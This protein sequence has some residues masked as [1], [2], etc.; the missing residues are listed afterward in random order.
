MMKNLQFLMLLLFM[1]SGS[2]AQQY[3]WLAINSPT[4]GNLRRIYISGSE[5]W[6]ASGSNI[7]YS[8]N[9]PSVQLSSKYSPSN[10][11][12]DMTFINQSGNKYGWTVGSSSLGA[13]TTDTAGIS[14][15]QMSLGGTS[16]YFCVSFPT[17]TLGFA[18]GSDKRLHKTVNGGVNWTDAG[19]V[20]GFSTVNT[21]FFVNSNTGYVGTADPRLAKTT[22]GGATWI[23]E[24]D[25]SASIND[26]YFYDST[27]GWAVGTS[28]ILYYNKG[29]W[30]QLNNTTGKS[31]NSVF[32]INANEGWI[33]GDG[34]T[35]LHSINGGANWTAQT[36]GTSS[37][38]VDIF[39]TSPT[40]GYAVGVNGTILHYTQ[41]TGV[42]EHPAQPTA[43]NLEQN[44][45]NPF[46][47]ETKISYSLAI[48]A[49]VQLTVC[50]MF[51]QQVALLDEGFKPAGSFSTDFTGEGL[52]S[53][54]YYYR[55]QCGD[56]HETRKMTLIK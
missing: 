34:G 38:L 33:V 25:I 4:T 49:Q 26:I 13:R 48:P 39:F 21:L 42:E 47:S 24:G 44:Y 17:T 50:N 22:D 8:S 31:L 23:D 37:N 55:L 3:G 2:F 35:I 27:H 41:I 46:D 14:W 1:A 10:G 28:D 20:M 6:L 15:T 5:A 32:F 9:Y 52:P 12:Y 30:T 56:R 54:I 36:S 18:S 45:P 11:L 51:G 16:S 40:N 29:I 53:G 43:F 19:V 7:Y